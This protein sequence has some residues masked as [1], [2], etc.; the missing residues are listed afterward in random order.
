MSY[1]HGETSFQRGDR[2]Q[3]TLYGRGTLACGYRDQRIGW[4]WS[5]QLDDGETISLV[6]GAFRMLGAIDYLAEIA[7]KFQVERNAL[8]EV[9]DEMKKRGRKKGFP[10]KL[11]K[12]RWLLVRMAGVYI[13]SKGKL[14]EPMREALKLIPD[15]T[16]GAAGIKT[17]RLKGDQ[18]EGMRKLLEASACFHYRCYRPTTQLYPTT[19]GKALKEAAKQLDADPITLMGDVAR[20]AVTA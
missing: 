5:V 9:V 13:D 2:V 1:N 20:Q 6:E 18:V 17:I 4:V 16:P 14:T 3:T 8:R 11:T 19:D 7:P 12:Q 10:V 15:Y